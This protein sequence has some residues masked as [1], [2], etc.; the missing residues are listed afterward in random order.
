M[1]AIFNATA[2]ADDHECFNCHQI[3][4]IRPNCPHPP[5]RTQPTLANTQL[6]PRRGGRGAA[7]R[8]MGGTP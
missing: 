8:G 5:V 1:Q 3:S 4:H 2:T 7:S 6:Y